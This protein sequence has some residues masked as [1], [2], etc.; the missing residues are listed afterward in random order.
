MDFFALST[1]RNFTQNN[2]SINGDTLSISIIDNTATDLGSQ[3]YTGQFSLKELLE[4]NSQDHGCIAIFPAQYTPDAPLI[5]VETTQISFPSRTGVNLSQNTPETMVGKQH[6]GSPF[7][8]L[9]EKYG[10]Y[11]FVYILTPFKGCSAND[12]TFVY[13]DTQNAVVTNNGNPVTSLKMS[14]MKSFLDAWMPIKITGPS[15][16][17]A[18]EKDTYTV[19]CPDN[20]TVYLTAD[21]GVINRNRIANNGTFTLDTSGLEAGEV[22]NIKAGYKF[23]SGVST[24]KIT[25]E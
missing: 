15:S 7:S 4:K 14:S 5:A 25:L 11:A 1:N 3:T 10:S 8:V 22:V 17:N 23:W 9:S 12:V 19:T 24:T 16:V 2:I 21:I 13:R 18:G 6:A 20:A